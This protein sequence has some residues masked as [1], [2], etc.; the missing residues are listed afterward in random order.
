M[1][2]RTERW[3]TRTLGVVLGVQVVGAVF[4]IV[5]R[6]GE[7]DLFAN[8]VLSLETVLKPGTSLP[9]AHA[10]LVATSL[11][12]YG[13]LRFED[14]GGNDKDG[15]LV[16]SLLAPNDQVLGTTGTEYHLSP[17]LPKGGGYFSVM[18][19]FAPPEGSTVHIESAV[20]STDAVPSAWSFW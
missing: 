16:V 13:R 9:H 2:K 15:Q 8:G 17:R 11:R 10:V 5:F 3:M 12:I 19:P 14:T 7:T 1:K 4:W 6:P 20:G 18:L